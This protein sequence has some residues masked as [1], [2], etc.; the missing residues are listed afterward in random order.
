RQLDNPTLLGN[1]T[2][3]ANATIR[4]FC[5]IHDHIVRLEPAG[6]PEGKTERLPWFNVRSKST[7][8]IQRPETR[9][10]ASGKQTL[11]IFP[12]QRGLIC[13]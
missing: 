12:V 2:K 1:R 11:A 7:E 13:G 5:L 10:P 9:K 3:S 8:A 6:M 4:S